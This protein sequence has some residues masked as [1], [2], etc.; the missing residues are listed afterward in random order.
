MNTA[1]TATIGG[2]IVGAAYLVYVDGIGTRQVATDGSVSVP[3]PAGRHTVGVSL[4]ATPT[5]PKP[6]QTPTFTAVPT[7]TKTPTQTLSQWWRRKK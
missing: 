2:L 7:V 4:L 1:T 5:L 3:I 6:T